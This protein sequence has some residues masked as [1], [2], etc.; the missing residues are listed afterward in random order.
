MLKLSDISFANT[1][2]QVDGLLNSVKAKKLY[3]AI[4]AVLVG[5]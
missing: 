4:V 1:G 5:R 3:W 2:Q